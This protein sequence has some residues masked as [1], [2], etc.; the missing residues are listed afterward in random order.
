[1]PFTYT[2]STKTTPDQFWEQRAQEK[3]EA[4]QAQKPPPRLA[5]L[6]AQ[7]RQ[8]DDARFSEHQKSVNEGQHPLDA[9]SWAFRQAMR[10]NR[11]AP[12]LQ[13]ELRKR[14]NGER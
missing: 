8:G 14:I 10:V 3:R 7:R 12:Q 4:M 1:M 2:P 6:S 13:E 9:Q 11:R 5:E